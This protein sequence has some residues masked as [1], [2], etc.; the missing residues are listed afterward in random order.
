MTRRT[1]IAISLLLSIAFATEMPL[2]LGQNISSG[3]APRLILN[4]YLDDTGK[5]LVTGYVEHP[6]RLAFLKSSK[7]NYENETQQLYALTNAL[8]MKSG[9]IWT[10]LFESSSYYED[11]HVTFYLPSDFT[12]INVSSSQGLDHLFSAS[13]DSLKVD[14]QGY[15]V[16]NPMAGIEYQQ[17]L[18]SSAHQNPLPSFLLPL[19]LVLILFAGA[20]TAFIWRYR[21]QPQREPVPS[22]VDA[23]SVI[24]DE[25]RDTPPEAISIAPGIA[26]EV[27]GDDT[28]E[29]GIIYSPQ[30][31]ESYEDN[32]S[33]KPG[34]FEDGDRNAGA[35]MEIDNASDE[36]V[37]EEKLVTNAIIPPIS[38]PAEKIEISSE[39]S[40]VMETLTPKERAVLQ[41]LIDCG[42]RS[43]QAD[44]R[45]E[46]H[47]PKS[48]LTG[49]ISSLERRK[50]VT[51][52]EWGRT[53][54]IELS[55]WF[56]S[57]KN[58]PN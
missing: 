39:M 1:Y 13:N 32:L 50:L 33:L 46:T 31:T 19:S 56:L 52:K 38:S 17:P 4:I 7:Y 48:S 16:L 18:E 36:D 53:N 41:A 45:Y 24:R 22:G 12:V 8:T 42:G 11:Y 6:E 30:K 55:Q 57:K 26:A 5:A 43:T 21:V 35:G 54:I 40:A 37:G 34:T 20:T 25:V 3:E 47:T 27:P 51:K 44:L 49:I 29:D 58:G 9:D 2:V 23:K 15:D 28:H 14:F 10:I